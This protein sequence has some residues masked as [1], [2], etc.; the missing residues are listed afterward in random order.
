MRG[1][2][3]ECG[4]EG[5]SKVKLAD[6]RGRKWDL[7]STESSCLGDR[8]GGVYASRKSLPYL[9]NRKQCCVFERS[10]PCR[11]ARGGKFWLDIINPHLE[12]WVSARLFQKQW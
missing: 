10:K 12:P 5:E 9:R 6:N 1:S 4:R 7:H 11:E 8:E 2:H 3:L